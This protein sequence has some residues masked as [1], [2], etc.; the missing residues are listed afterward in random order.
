A[1]PMRYVIEKNR[2]SGLAWGA[3]GRCIL[4]FLSSEEINAVISASE[5]SPSDGRPL[6]EQELRESLA[7][8]RRKGYALTESQ[9]A[10][11]V[12]GLAMPIFDASSKVCGSVAISIPDFRFSTHDLER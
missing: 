11:G 5:P 3:S 2:T 4:A 8:I 9:R 12:Y 10:A 1:H 6:D 7:E